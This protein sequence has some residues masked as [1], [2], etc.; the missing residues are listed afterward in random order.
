MPGRYAVTSMR[1]TASSSAGAGDGDEAP[2]ARRAHAAPAV[3]APASVLAGL[4]PGR[5]KTSAVSG[6]IRLSALIPGATGGPTLTLDA[7]ATRDWQA[8]VK[9]L[10]V[11]R[12]LLP[13]R[14]GNIQSDIYRSGGRSLLRA[15]ALYGQA[16]RLDPAGTVQ[17]ALR[18]GTANCWGQAHLMSALLAD[19]GLRKPVITVRVRGVDH[20]LTVVGDW[21]APGHKL[22]IDSWPVYATPLA[23]EEFPLGH[24]VE[25]IH[26]YAPGYPGP[27]AFDAIQQ[28]AQQLLDDRQFAAFRPQWAITPGSDFLA[29]LAASGSIE[30][31]YQQWHAGR[32]TDTMYLGQDALGTVQTFRAEVDARVVAEHRHAL[33]GLRPVSPLFEANGTVHRR[34]D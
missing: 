7:E 27:L 22:A 4:L 21:R 33:R 32:H 11:Q 12:A 19:A 28:G 9:A 18:L 20:A 29:R 8:G 16:S 24:L 2:D 15:Q 31:S 17:D 1:A 5:M 13:L 30:K 6:R 10:G 25:A 3:S 23:L 34:D 26:T 14:S